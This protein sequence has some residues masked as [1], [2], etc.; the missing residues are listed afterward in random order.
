[1]SQILQALG[2]SN[3]NALVN[4]PVGRTAE[5]VG[6]MADLPGQALGALTQLPPQLMALLSGTTPDTRLPSA[7]GVPSFAGQARQAFG[8][9]PVEQLPTATGRA[10]GTAYQQLGPMLTAGLAG[11]GAQ[12][13]VALGERGAVGAKA[14]E[15]AGPLWRSPLEEAISTWQS[16][17]T[18]DQLRAHLKHFKGAE[19][20]AKATALLPENLPSGMFHKDEILDYVKYMRKERG[21][22]VGEKV[23]GAPPPKGEYVAPAGKFDP[24][25]YPSLNTPGHTP[26]TY[27]ELFVTGPVKDSSNAVSLKKM[28]DSSFL[29]L[30]KYSE[31]LNAVLDEKGVPATEANKLLDP[32]Y[33][34]L[35]K[36]NGEHSKAYG[37]YVHDTM[38]WNDGHAQYSDIPNPIVRLRFHERPDVD[39][40]KTLHIDEMQKPTHDNQAKMPKWA[41]DMAYS[42]GMKRAIRYAVDHDLEQITW[43]TG[44]QQAER[45]NL[46][47]KNITAIFHEDEDNIAAVVNGRATTLDKDQVAELKKMLGPRASELRPDARGIDLSKEPLTIGGEWAKNLYDKKLVNETNKLVKKWGGKVDVG[48]LGVPD[49]KKLMD[50]H[51]DIE[52]RVANMVI[53]APGRAELIKRADS[54]SRMLDTNTIPPTPTK[55]H[56]LRVTPEM[57]K[58]A[59][60]G[61]ELS[62]AESD[63]GVA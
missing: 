22:E 13:A 26:G 28:Y 3:T 35:Y 38:G 56:R 23:L 14:A 29:K 30:R 1:M 7:P 43:T 32:E 27:R 33:A 39:G 44:E 55:V 53:G 11:K 57:K 60:R 17:G 61:M 37:D 59:K 12:G 5:G 42:L 20:E 47:L 40:A 25:D 18:V 19:A 16:K 48:E 10:L 2:T 63:R 36:L 15:E 58:Q 34:R 52:R 45:Y 50:E 8:I 49:A 31:W 51:V 46:Q 4:E 41:G 62:Q 9:P 54:I 24:V 21:L 6:G